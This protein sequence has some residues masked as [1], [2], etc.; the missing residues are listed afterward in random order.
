MTGTEKRDP[1]HVVVVRHRTD[2]EVD[3]NKTRL[4]LTREALIDL[5]SEAK[6]QGSFHQDDGIDYFCSPPGFATCHE[7]F[8]IPGWAFRWDNALLVAFL[9]QGAIMV[10]PLDITVETITR[11]TPRT[12]R[13]E[14]C[15]SSK[16]I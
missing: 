13:G 2:M 4:V 10:D 5:H 9:L 15:V 7:G 14:G 6:A 11:S 12:R 3:L 16:K 8:H 1:P